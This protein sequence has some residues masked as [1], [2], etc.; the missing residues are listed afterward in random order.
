MPLPEVDTQYLLEVLVD[1]L[2][3]PSP[4]GYTHMAIART[5]EALLKFPQLSLAT[6]R[7]GALVATWPGLDGDAPRGLTAH[8]D[9]LGAMV[10]VIKP[11]GRLKLTRIGGFA[12]N[13]RSLFGK[14]AL[15]Y[16][17]IGAIDGWHYHRNPRGALC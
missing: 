2:N 4:T 12:W 8:A 11:D 14:L 7:K 3:T 5:E 15:K 17:A 10:K 16:K 6:T 9:T 13:Y 1:L